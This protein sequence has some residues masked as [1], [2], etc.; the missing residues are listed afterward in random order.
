[1]K[2]INKNSKRHKF[3]WDEKGSKWK[4]IEWEVL[5]TQTVT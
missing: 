3:S 1:M 4:C 5:Q 2:L